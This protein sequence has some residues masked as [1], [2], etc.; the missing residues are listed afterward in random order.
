MDDAYALYL[1]D[2][3]TLSGDE[4]TDLLANLLGA[5]RRE[6]SYEE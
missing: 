5:Y 3:I 2:D 1:K 4:K 6:E